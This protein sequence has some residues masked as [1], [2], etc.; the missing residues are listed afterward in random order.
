MGS[1]NELEVN[2][3]KYCSTCKYEKIDEFKDPCNE[4]LEYPTNAYSCK[5]I[6]YKKNKKSSCKLSIDSGGSNE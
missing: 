5:P 1:N 6:N 2:F 3:H 4:C